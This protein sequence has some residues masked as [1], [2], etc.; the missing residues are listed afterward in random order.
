[1][2]NAHR[3]AYNGG[4]SVHETIACYSQHDK[5]LRPPSE[6]GDTDAVLA[7][8]THNNTIVSCCH[9]MVLNKCSMLCHR[10]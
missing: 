9:D 8:R 1:M 5:V 6:A 2:E 4:L 3:V 7:A 10:P